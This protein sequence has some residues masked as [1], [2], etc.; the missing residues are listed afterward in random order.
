MGLLFDAD[1]WDKR[2]VMLLHLRRDNESFE[3]LQRAV[4]LNPQLAEAWF[5]MGTILYAYGRYE[6]GAAH[7]ENAH[8]L[9]HPRAADLLRQCRRDA[10]AE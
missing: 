2:G 8:R 9:G 6:Q 3:S 7:L 5:L 10:Q 1:A 4:E